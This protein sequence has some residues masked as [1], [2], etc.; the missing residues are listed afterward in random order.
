MRPVVYFEDCLLVPCVHC[1]FCCAVQCGLAA[2]HSILKAL[3]HALVLMH[4]VNELPCMFED[5][6]AH[7]TK[8]K[9]ENGASMG[10]VERLHASCHWYAERLTPVTGFPGKPLALVAQHKAH[11]GCTCIQQQH[12]F[13][14]I[15]ALQY[16]HH[17][18]DVS[19]SLSQRHSKAKLSFH[20][21]QLTVSSSMQ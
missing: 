12:M 15:R 2:T 17:P 9:H 1:A 16:L 14:A 18:Q 7:L 11:S 21:L 4:S 10:H 8:C 6:R 13:L 3:A 19:V 5:V 20:C